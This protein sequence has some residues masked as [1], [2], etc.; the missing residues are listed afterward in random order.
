[1]KFER[2]TSQRGIVRLVGLEGG[3]IVKWAAKRGEMQIWK[4]LPV[5]YPVALFQNTCNYPSIS[6]KGRYQLFG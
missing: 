1:M 5:S 6:L 3:A 4:R 2:K